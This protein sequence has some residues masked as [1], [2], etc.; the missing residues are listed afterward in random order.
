MHPNAYWLW[1]QHG[2]GP[3]SSKLHRIL[4]HFGDAQEF[5]QAGLQGW[6]MLG[7]FTQRELQTLSAYSLEEA[8][9]ALEYCWNVGQQVITLGDE[10]FPFLLR[11]IYPMPCAL[12]VLGNLPDFDTFPAIAVVGTRDA[13]E[14]GKEIAFELSYGLAQ[15]GVTIVSG[16]AL[17]IDSAAHKGAL[18]AHGKTICV[19]G[20]GIGYGYLNENAPLREAIAKSGAL[21]SEFPVNTPPS[22]TTFPVRNRLISGLC[23]GTL[24]VEA[25]SKSGSLIT[26]K[27]AMEQN[28]DVFAVPNGLHNPVS[29][30]ANRL[31]QTGAKMVTCVEDMLEEYRMQFPALGKPVCRSVPPTVRSIRR[32]HPTK[33]NPAIPERARVPNPAFSADAK[34]LLQ[35]LEHAPKTLAELEVQTGLSSARI[36]AAV[37]ELELCCYAVSYSGRRYGVPKN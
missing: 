9:A 20:C 22:R 26:A 12:Y 13:T 37:T 27:A 5:Y 29:Q 6:K 32:E 17:G 25:A 35:Y 34:L 33:E 15:A 3:G 21:I 8:Q 18:R 11:Q 19:L 23:Q 4:D 1:L 16:G 2:I 7:C 10:E 30:G 14:S 24:V 36:L 31:I 28:R